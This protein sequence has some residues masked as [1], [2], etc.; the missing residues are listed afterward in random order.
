M[1]TSFRMVRQAVQLLQ[2]R[3]LVAKLAF[4][5]AAVVI[6]AAVLWTRQSPDAL[7]GVASFGG[8]IEEVAFWAAPGLVLY[9]LLTRTATAIVVEGT[10]L[11]ALLTWGWWS[12]A[13]DWHSTAAL[14]PAM[15]G[16]F[17]APSVVLGGLIVQ[18]V[19]QLA[20]R[21]RRQAPRP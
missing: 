3:R 5:L 21:R 9:L 12:S 15:T 16:W 20:R 10:A 2:P 17:L 11:V 14:G 13:T 1:P 7:L 4:I 6:A 19:V 8:A 18:L